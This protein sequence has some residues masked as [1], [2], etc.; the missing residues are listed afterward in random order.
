MYNYNELQAVSLSPTKKDYYQIWNELIEVAS[1]L[2]ARWDPS[3]TNESDPGIIL[4]KVLTAIADKLNYNIDANT[5]EAFLPSAAQ[6]ASMRK[7]CE[8]LGYTMAYFKSATTRIRITYKGSTF[9]Q[10]GDT[11]KSIPIGRFTN[12]KDKD[13]TINYV[14]LEPVYLSPSVKSA[15][16]ECAEGELVTCQTN[17]GT[18]VTIDHLDDNNR[19]YFPEQQIASNDGCIFVANVEDPNNFWK[20]V[21]NLNTQLLGEK[22]FKFGF[23]ST[24]GLPFIQF[25]EDISSLIRVGLVIRYLRTRGASGNIKLGI[26][27]KLEKPTSWDTLIEELSS[28]S[29]AVKADE[30]VEGNLGSEVDTSWANIDLYGV[31]NLSPSRNGKNPETIDEAYWNYQKTIGTF[32]TLVTCRDY[33]NRI[34]QMTTSDTDSTPLVSNVIVSDI[35]DDINRAYTLCTYTDTGLEHARHSYKDGDANR[36]DYFDLILYPFETVYGLNTPN[37]F[38]SSFKYSDRRLTEIQT[39]LDENKT[40]AHK[41]K[42]PANGDIVCVKIYNQYSARLTTTSKVSILEATEIESAAHMALFG[43]YN[44]RQL[45]L[46][47]ELPY[48]E[49]LKTLT[50]ADARIKNVILDDPRLSVVVC[51]K[52]GSEVQ[53]IGDQVYETKAEAEKAANYYKQLVM[54]NVLAGKISLFNYDTKFAT[55]FT[56]SEYPTDT[57]RTAT[58]SRL[59]S[60]YETVNPVKGFTFGQLANPT[61][62]PTYFTTQ[63]GTLEFKLF[64]DAELG[65]NEPSAEDITALLEL[66]KSINIDV[67]ARGAA[68]PT[69][70]ITY[71]PV[72]DDNKGYRLELKVTDGA[73]QNDPCNITE[74]KSLSLSPAPYL[75][76]SNLD[77]PITICQIPLNATY[78]VGADTPNTEIFDKVHFSVTADAAFDEVADDELRAIF[79][80][81]TFYP[82]SKLKVTKSG[83]RTAATDVANDYE[84]TTL[85]FDQ[86]L[87]SLQAGAEVAVKTYWLGMAPPQNIDPD[88]A[89]LLVT[90]ENTSWVFKVKSNQYSTIGTVVANLNSADPKQVDLYLQTDNGTSNGSENILP[91]SLQFAESVSDIK[92]DTSK[93]FITFR[94]TITTTTTTDSGIVD[95]VD[96]VTDYEYSIANLVSFILVNN[97]LVCVLNDAYFTYAENGENGENGAKEVLGLVSIVANGVEDYAPTYSEETINNITVRTWQPSSIIYTLDRSALTVKVSGKSY[98]YY[99]PHFEGFLAEERIFRNNDGTV[100][101]AVRTANQHTQPSFKTATNEDYKFCLSRFGQQTLVWNYPGSAAVVSKESAEPVSY[102]TFLDLATLNKCILPN[103]DGELVNDDQPE[104]PIKATKLTTRLDIQTENLSEEDPLVLTQGEVVQFR[105]PNFKTNITYPA[106]VNYYA[107]LPTKRASATSTGANKALAIPATMLDLRHF[108]GGGKEVE[109]TLNN[110]PKYTKYYN[111]GSKTLITENRQYT[112]SRTWTRRLSWEEKVN[113]LP[114]A[115]MLKK[116]TTKS[117]F[118]K[119]ADQATANL[120]YS[121]AVKNYGAVFI[122]DYDTEAAEIDANNRIAKGETLDPVI[123]RAK[124]RYKLYEAKSGTVIPDNTDFY[125]VHLTEAN[126]ALFVQWLQGTACSAITNEPI[127]YR[128]SDGIVLSGERLIQSIYSQGRSNMSRQIGTLVDKEKFKYT[129]EHSISKTGYSALTEYFVPELHTKTTSSHTANGLGQDAS[130]SGLA[131]NSEYEL[132]AGEYILLNYSSSEGQAEGVTVPK[133]IALGPGSI[134]KANFELIDSAENALLHPYTKT[135]GYGPWRVEGKTGPATLI[136]PDAIPGMFAFGA[137]EQIEVREPVTVTLDGEVSNLFWEVGEKEIRDGYEY[138][139]FKDGKYILQPGE[140]LFYTNASKESMTYYSTGT[141]ISCGSATPILRR[142]QITGEISLENADEVGLVAS[143]PWTTFNLSGEDAAVTIHEYQMIT[144]VEGDTLSKVV[145]PDDS[146]TLST[147]FVNVEAADYIVSGTGGSLPKLE[148]A[149]FKWQ[150]KAQLDI[151]TS[152]TKAQR[153]TVHRTKSGAELARDSFVIKGEIQKGDTV[154]EKDLY[155]ITPQAKATDEG[156]EVIPITLYTDIPFVS[157]SGAV[158]FEEGK[159]PTIKLCEYSPLQSTPLGENSLKTNYSLAYV[160]DFASYPAVNGEVDLKILVPEGHVALLTAYVISDTIPSDIT[161]LKNNTTGAYMGFTSAAE[162]SELEIFNFKY[163]PENNSESSNAFGTWWQGDT[164]DTKQIEDS[165]YLLRKGLNTICIPESTT[166]TFKT[167]KACEKDVLKLG[168]VK[169]IPKDYPLNYKL[170]FDSRLII[171]DQDID[172]VLHFK[173]KTSNTTQASTANSLGHLSIGVKEVLEYIAEHDPDNQFFYTHEPANTSGLD[174]NEYDLTATLS[175]PAAWF[176]KQN[177]VNK[178]VVAQLDTKYIGE[179]VIVSKFSR[180]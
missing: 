68:K 53:V 42:T 152:S 163:D 71:S 16:V 151:A 78:A 131:P 94:H 91:F 157:A 4:L 37:E 49:I 32:D 148:I 24:V 11:V 127:K 36:I 95:T 130:A 115:L 77:L 30:L 66:I 43:A 161:A 34:Y 154:E 58:A 146:T 112:S 141:E 159:I 109:E 74:I 174:L 158:A 70:H 79:T 162:G 108:F 25:P 135:S 88:K 169:I 172:P 99:A 180:S 28:A 5:L 101:V 110:Y 102:D 105:A 133:N 113:S 15:V 100:E 84:S 61:E 19:F 106:Y 147:E 69:Y 6:E 64:E 65:S 17:N 145:F 178:F 47:E 87:E 29:G 50:Y 8:M 44:M 20:A 121:M 142:K 129:V 107:H 26:L 56:E 46:G 86:D 175:K 13:S 48:D 134:V 119:T 93:Q 10:D 35:R 164:D 122:L 92:I 167:T 80:G 21:D 57:I 138:F 63:A 90:A 104:T 31:A 27:Q 117:C 62:T 9:P 144:L 12:I 114:E 153:L 125:V 149:G 155:I 97:S 111:S 118:E 51:L 7:L 85:T 54:A 137:T 73:E 40:M 173:Y 14:T 116:F 67:F 150:A 132:K 22:V 75:D 124:K 96:T 179:Y 176:D 82:A 76:Y 136:V 98:V 165:I 83:D 1:K 38:N 120:D 52:D 123:E 41:F 140:Y 55:E 139:P 143:I 81:V 33:M 177:L 168:K 128:T 89:E 59:D 2:S 3:A 103:D 45:S 156:V 171:A 170:A 166:L 23:D 126:L 18:T 60:T 39:Y 160:D 72:K